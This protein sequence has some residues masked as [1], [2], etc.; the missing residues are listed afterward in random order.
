MSTPG[1]RL[2]AITLKTTRES[3]FTLHNE[4]QTLTLAVMARHAMQAFG[5]GIP[6]TLRLLRQFISPIEEIVILQSIKVRGRMTL[7]LNVVDT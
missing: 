2:L 6:N 7:V 1:A 3:A 5:M 4:S